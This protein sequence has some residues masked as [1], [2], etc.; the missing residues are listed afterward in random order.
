MALI[1]MDCTPHYAKTNFG[2]DTD[3]MKFY[4]T[5]YST[6]YGHEGFLPRTGVHSG[7]GYVANRRPALYYTPSLDRLD[8]PILGQLLQDNYLSIT[9]KHFVPYGLPDGKEDL[10]HKLHSI[11][12][13][14]TRTKPLNFPFFKDMKEV[15]IDT[16][17]HGPSIITGIE[18]KHVPLLHQIQPKDPVIQENGGHGPLYMSTEYK[19]KYKLKPQDSQAFSQHKTAGKKERSGFTAGSDLKPITFHHPSAYR[20]DQPGY[21]TDRPTG[22]S[23][24]KSDYLPSGNLHE[25]AF[26]PA[27]ANRS[28]RGT[29][30][31]NEVR[32][33]LDTAQSNELQNLPADRIVKLKKE[34]P[35]EYLHRTHLE[36]PSSIN[37]LT[38]TK[39]VHRPLGE[40]LPCNISVGAQ[41][42]TG[43]TTNEKGYVHPSKSAS[44]A[45]RFL[46]NYKLRFDDKTPKGVDREGWTRGGIQKQLSDGFVRSTHL[47]KY[48]SECNITE[49][50]RQIHPHVV[51]TIKSVDKHHDHQTNDHKQCPPGLTL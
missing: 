19:T 25:D 41:G 9:K 6:S 20:G 45:N 36:D 43:F 12:S 15:H 30:F 8:N 39:P 29:G 24:S 2:A 4:S 13:G 7:A 35:V 28:D 3:P 51:R 22:I 31:T 47:H 50:L 49:S 27:I 38:Y 16:R 44:D 48:G 33:S 32:L 1:S 34:D 10:P 42:S 26:L 21:C 46:T 23:I 37:T 11:G 18:P 5:T 40:K 17:N 14:F